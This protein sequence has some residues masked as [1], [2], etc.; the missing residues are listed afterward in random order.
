M[1]DQPRQRS[2]WRLSLFVFLGVTG[3]YLF[4]ARPAEPVND[5]T[6]KDNLAYLALGR[7]GLVIVDAS[8]PGQP[9]EIGSFD[10]RG[11]AN[12][13]ATTA[14]ENSYIADGRDGLRILDVSNP[15]NPREISAY[16]SPGYAQ[17]L[18]VVNNTVY[19]ADGGSGL[20][21]INVKDKKNPFLVSS[22]SIRGNIRRVA[23]QG[24][25]AYLGDNQNQ[26]R[27][28]NVS[29]PNQ[30]EEV[31]VLDVG[32][33]IQDMDL[34]E[35]K[36][37]LATGTQGMVI[38][39]IADPQQPREITSIETDGSVQGVA[40]NS[41][42]V[43]FLADG[44]K[45]LLAYDI[46]DLN[47]IERVGSFDN[48]LN[49]NQVVL[50]G[51]GL[52]LADRDSALHV[53]DAEVT[54]AS[55]SVS[56]TEQQQGSAHSVAVNEKFSFLVFA[57]QG[58]RVMDVSNPS[59]PS[60]V[61][62]YDSPG[63]SVDVTLSGDF[64]YLADGAAGMQ[65]LF[66]ENSTTQ[67]PEISAI[68][69]V[70]TLGEANQA[71]VVGQTIYMADGSG[72]LSVI[73]MVNP[74]QPVI[75]GTEDTPGN[76]RG[77]AVLGD[78]AYIADG[79]AGLRVINILDGSKPAEV[80][81]ID[82]PGD[83][84]AV[85]VIQL[86]DP[87]NRKYAYVADDGGGL[88]VIDVTDPVVPVEIG[89]FT[90]YETVQDVIVSGENAYLAAGNLGLRIVRVA[91][92]AI[93]EEVGF[94]DTPGEALGLA[95]ENEISYVADNTRGMRNVDVAD[96]SAPVEI[97]FYDVPRVVRGVTVAENFAYLTDVESGF[98]IADVSDPQRL[99]QVGHYDQGGIVEAITVQGNVAYLADAIGLQ[100]VNVGDAR[101]PT[102]M[103]ELSTP[104]R[105][106]S[107]FVVDNLAYVT[108]SAYG[109]RI[110]DVSDPSTIVS[111][112]NHPTRGSGEDVFVAND[113]AYI[114]DGEAGLM[115]INMA[116][117][118]DPKTASVIDQFQNANSVVV[119]GD[120]AYLADETNGV[121][122]IDVSKPVAPETIAFVDTPG[123]ALDLE[124]SGVYLFVADG[125]A[126]VQVVYILNPTEPSLVGGVA[127][128]GF[129]LDLDVEWRA[130]GDGNP[131]RFLVY[132]AK[133]DRGLEILSV[134]KGL[135]AG[136]MGLYE[137]P[138]MAPVRQVAEDG[139]P[140]ISRPG[141]EK[142]SRTV[143]QT[144]FDVFVVGILGLL[145]W[146]GF[147]AQYVLPLN[148]LRERRAAI[149]RLVRYFMRTHGPA[150]RIENGKVIQSH[151]EK[152]RSSP[153]V[154]LLD[155][156]S[157]AMLRTKTTFVRAVGPGVVFT[158]GGE[159]LHQE[160]VD[161]H[162][163]VRPLPPLGPL[164]SEDPYAPWIRKKE[165]EKEYQARQNRRKET[166]GLTRDGVEIVPNILAVVK[167]KSLPG[168]GGTRFGFNSKSVSLAIT[169]EG[170]VPNGLRNVPWHEIPAYLAV[171]VWREYLG[172]FTL[173]EL[174]ISP[175]EES[176]YHSKTGG[177]TS[178]I[179]L[180]TSLQLNADIE[181]GQQQ[182]AS[183]LQLN[184]GDKP[185]QQDPKTGNQTRFELIL[186]MVK[187]RLTQATVAR[188]DE[189]GRE[190]NE[191]Q[192]SREY[193]ILEE[194]GI[195]V[196]DVS[197]SNPRFPRTV[198][199]Q[200]VQQWLSTWLERAVAD[201]DAIESRRALAGEK[202]KESALLEFAE[203]VAQ[204]IG[205][206]LVDD[207][208]NALP[209]ESKLR[210]DLKA[211]LELLVSG[212][213]QLLVRNTNLQ[214]WLM[215]EESE[216]NRLLEWIRRG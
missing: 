207:D 67:N 51:G 17:D 41:D 148:S 120:Y 94:Y 113:Y 193:Q 125:E 87:V 138:G 85:V 75:L 30:L 78:Y 192:D 175:D 154:I 27:V 183:G 119:L 178:Q 174:F 196:I 55:Q 77:V 176:S 159:F 18:D 190:T 73:S 177:G 167:T 162:T 171:E 116:D 201:R 71:A 168:Q 58:L 69:G 209:F 158:E 49:A 42:I 121:W 110:A 91:D 16:N 104:G 62:V 97:G 188:L 46:T 92:P 150:I 79:E 44:E 33:E 5:L 23:V 99:R 156:A 195:K 50:D 12:A 103:G 4:L 22:Y 130:E 45:G 81:A 170:I 145:V 146:L 66:L 210:P 137:T 191:T 123:T 212:T 200:L 181:A 164:G 65:V 29:K 24:N 59:S 216:L 129:S 57:D 74:A 151:G 53:V 187:L 35:N 112:S 52:Y 185:G 155:T 48:F 173:T 215:N 135:Q 25:Y 198:E 43:A 10:T 144:A 132:V 83:A 208:G 2:P 165:E 122:V 197:I 39:D 131:G 127:L 172:K 6:V 76:A 100:T 3:F 37:Y 160:A 186:R 80:G 89:S 205:E 82:T 36:A 15:Y 64:I 60:E 213:Q 179:N 118:R 88:R 54:L 56:S 86:P 13:V 28:V 20:L 184:S 206:T 157:A 214:Q 8:V 95:L 34:S 19:L 142:S 211:S 153:G 152:K 101:N 21:I 31:A 166:S 47:A 105:A 204:N 38:V 133:G 128:D 109:L 163:Q 141:K 134:G 147:F 72:G 180:G 136:T 115:I 143:R 203:G 11:S 189:Y 108:D 169:R 202:G 102:W 84:Q 194:M 161:L 26:F 70:D 1:S 199:S 96:P 98:R 106:N 139:F 111:L 107:L 7:A 124:V 140:I 117:P 32:G 90:A 63:A 126:G 14:G 40:V 182:P 93:I 9:E 61:A 68:A 149:G 114:A